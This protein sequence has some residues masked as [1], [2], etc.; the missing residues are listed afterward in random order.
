MRISD[1]ISDVCS[2]DLHRIGHRLDRLDLGK[3]VL[4]HMLAAPA[5]IGAQNRRHRFGGDLVAVRPSRLADPEDIAAAVAGHR[6][7]LGP[8]DV[9]LAP[10]V[11]AD[12]PLR[13]RKSVVMGKS[14]AV[15]LDLGGHRFLKK[16]KKKLK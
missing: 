10:P 8:P 16:K 6:P 3:I 14:V 4:Q 2:S 7:A 5:E 11:I 12:E 15:R 1:W 9:D 13:D